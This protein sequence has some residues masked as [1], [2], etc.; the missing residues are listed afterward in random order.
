MIDFN[1]VK[2]AASISSTWGGKLPL[3]WFAASTNHSL[4]METTNSLKKWKVRDTNRDA[5]FSVLHVISGRK[6]EC[7]PREAPA[8]PTKNLQFSFLDTAYTLY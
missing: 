6:C 1:G 8:A 5:P 2:P 4:M 3:V 7:A